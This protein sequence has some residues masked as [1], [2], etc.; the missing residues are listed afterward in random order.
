[1]ARPK[2][3]A[4]EQPLGLDGDKLLTEN[5]N[6]QQSEE[7]VAKQEGKEQAKDSVTNGLPFALKDD[8][9][10]YPTCSSD[11]SFTIYAP[12]DIETHEGRIVVDT[13]VILNEGYRGIILPVPDNAI[14]GLPTES[15]YRLSNSDV[16]P[17]QAEEGKEIRLVLSINDETMIHEQTS[18]GSHSRNLFIPK[19]TP[20]AEIMIFKL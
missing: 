11:G 20:L 5:N 10:L 18:F 13:G 7:K 9:I 6:A 19:R 16:I 4:V 8:S 17:L 2:K 12:A 3:T 1:M 14:S 15:N